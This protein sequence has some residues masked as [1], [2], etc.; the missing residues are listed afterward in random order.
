MDRDGLVIEA[1]KHAEREEAIVVRLYEAYGTRGSARLA[2]TLPVKQAFRADLMERAGEA[3]D[4]RNGQIAFTVAPYEIV[5]F[6]L[7]L[8]EGS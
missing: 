1:I 6:I 7:F 2:T 3:V 4:C 5:T 8:E